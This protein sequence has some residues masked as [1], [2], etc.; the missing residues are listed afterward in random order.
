MKKNTPT[1]RR[2]AKQGK[3]DRPP[4]ARLDSMPKKPTPPK[5]I[6]ETEKNL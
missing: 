3:T 2:A 1:K 4:T 6:G 5:Y